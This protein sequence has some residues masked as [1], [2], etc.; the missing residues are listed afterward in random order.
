MDQTLK[1]EEFLKK[2]GGNNRLKAYISTKEWLN[3]RLRGKYLPDFIVLKNKRMAE[4]S[5]IIILHI[6]F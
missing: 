3:K 2:T 1:K 4:Y 6:S 5:L